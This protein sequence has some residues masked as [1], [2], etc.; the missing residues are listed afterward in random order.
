[1]LTS[2]LCRGFQRQVNKLE[3]VDLVCK[4]K[5]ELVVDG[6]TERAAVGMVEDGDEGLRQL[7]PQLLL[8]QVL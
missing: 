7:V 6:Q 1:M 2:T 4:L 8:P 5:N 3:L